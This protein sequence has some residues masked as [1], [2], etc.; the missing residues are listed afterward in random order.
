VLHS[1]VAGAIEE[2]PMSAG[3]RLGT[4]ENTETP[5][6]FV[7]VELAPGG[8]AL[9]TARRFARTIAVTIDLAR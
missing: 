5:L 4:V 9:T 8:H 2:D 3:F 7:A 1:A 6:S